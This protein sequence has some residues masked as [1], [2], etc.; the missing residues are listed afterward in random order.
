M[1]NK[2]EKYDIWQKKLDGIVNSKKLNDS[3]I[4][5]INELKKSLNSKYL[6]KNANLKYTNYYNNYL[7]EMK[8]IGFTLFS[9]EEMITYYTKIN[10]TDLVA[11]THCNC[12]TSDDWCITGDCFYWHC[13]T[14]DAGCGWRLDQECNG[15]CAQ[16]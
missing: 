3:Q 6:E 1:L 5:Y 2:N 4:K 10:E 11:G 13:S 14:G 7:K 9:K 8:K 15:L 16:S 12:N